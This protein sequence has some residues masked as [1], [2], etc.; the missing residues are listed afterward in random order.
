MKF[1]KPLETNLARLLR[2]STLRKKIALQLIKLVVSYRQKKP[3]CLNYSDDISLGIYQR[4]H[5]FCG[6][7]LAD[8][9][10]VC[11][12]KMLQREHEYLTF[13]ALTYALMDMQ[14]NYPKPC[15]K[16]ENFLKFA[17]YWLQLAQD[18]NICYLPQGMI[19]CF[20]G[21]KGQN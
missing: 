5:N 14:W 6:T 7:E 18:S 17:K 19:E 11:L 8:L 2:G 3:L 21:E 1:A 12:F 20:A 10:Y 4:L 15:A 16:S 13:S 9:S